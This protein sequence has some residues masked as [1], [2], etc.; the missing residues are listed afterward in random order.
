MLGV[1]AS[2]KRLAMALL[3]RLN[4]AMM[5][6]NRKDISATNGPVFLEPILPVKATK[7]AWGDVWPEKSDRDEWVHRFGNLCL[8]SK[9]VETQ[10]SKLPFPEKKER[11]KTEIWPLTSRLDEVTS[12]EKTGLKENAATMM[13]L[14]ESIWGLQ[15]T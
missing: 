3:K 4:R 1:N 14:M 6:Q 9:Q 5:L 12:W 13:G 15:L 8:V 2:G 11:Y 7:K 10:E